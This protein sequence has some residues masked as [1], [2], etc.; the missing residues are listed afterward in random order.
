MIV[1]SAAR[2]EPHFV[3]AMH[4]H[5]L[6]AGQFAR[7]FGNE[8]FEPVAPRDVVIDMVDNHDRG[9]DEWDAAPEADPLTRLPYSLART[10]MEAVLRTNVG[11]PDFN[12]PRHAYAGL[13]SSMHTSG[14]YNGR[15]GYS[16]HIV[17]DKIADE[18]RPGVDAMLEGEQRR[19]ERLTERLAADPETRPWVADRHKFQNYKQLQFFDTLALYF[20][21]NHA[22]ER[23]RVSFQH[24]PLNAGEDV[25]VTI[26]PGDDRRYVLKLYPFS[27]DPFEVS[28]RGR[29][30]TPIAAGNKRSAAEILDAIPFAEE[31]VTLVAA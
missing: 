22:R 10:P 30:M 26:E 18:W 13:L 2:G 29:N 14:L 1:Q 9:W 28:F 19:R 11:S 21:M 20:N 7:A 27:T 25:T 3:I 5:T 17:I 16:D 8:R 4:D 24:V 6:F 23:S 31:K 15:F 12:E